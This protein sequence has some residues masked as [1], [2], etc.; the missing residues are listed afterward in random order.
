[1]EQDMNSIFVERNESVRGIM[2]ATISGTNILL[3]GKA[4]VAKSA[5][6]SQWNRRIKDSI[7]FEWLLNKFSTPE[8]L[9]GPYSFTQLE[10]DKYVRMTKGKLPEADTAFVDEIFKGNPSV[11]NAMLKI[12]NE[13][14][15]YNDYTPTKLDLI[16]VAG[17]SNE[18]PESDDGLDAFL[19]RFLLKYEVEHIKEDGNFLTMLD[20]DIDREPH[21][22]LSKTDIHAAQAV[23]REI[24]FPNE[25]KQI[26]VK[27]R[28]TLRYE[29]LSVSDRTFK[30]SVR[31]IKAQAFL[32]GRNKIDT[33]DFEILKHITWTDPN[34]KKKAQSL[35]LEL[36][37][38]EKNRVFEIL[39]NCRQSHG[40]V[41][42]NKEN[43]KR[44]DAAVEALHKLKDGLKEI[45]G[46]RQQMVQRNADVSE[47]ERIENEIEAMKRGLLIDEIGVGKF[48]K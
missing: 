31:L 48:M 18:V 30:T 42:E 43:K 11:L 33:P 12:L 20:S 1:V 39:E 32:A 14:V 26:Y 35:I 38:P 4:G 47:V 28:K 22:F 24:E 46:L 44:T 6:I 41:M 13:R 3:L 25:M 5:L 34:Q 9:F 21:A 19:D 8:E 45:A 27:L 23:A 17:A 40:K 37:A 15:F 7:Y 36:I 29:G 2:V 10:F 16:T